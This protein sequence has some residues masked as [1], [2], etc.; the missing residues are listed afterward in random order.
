VNDQVGIGVVGSNTLTLTTNISSATGLFQ[1]Q[2]ADV[3]YTVTANGRV[4][5]TEGTTTTEILY[6]ISPAQYVGIST[7]ANARVDA[8]QQ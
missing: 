6:L 3:S 5:L 2:T 1:N 7:D 8:Y 4:A